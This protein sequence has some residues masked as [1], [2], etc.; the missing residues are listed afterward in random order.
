MTIYIVLESFTLL[1]RSAKFLRVQRHLILKNVQ[2]RQVFEFSR[3]SLGYHDERTFP[4]AERQN[5][6][7][8][9]PSHIS[10]GVF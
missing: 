8:L 6:N 5:Y 3:R 7:G 1:E 10:G 9:F 2:H 4:F